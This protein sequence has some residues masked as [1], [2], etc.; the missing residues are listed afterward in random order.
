MSWSASLVRLL[1]TRAPWAVALCY[2]LLIQAALAP[3][4]GTA[5]ALS[6]LDPSA[7]V[8]CL[9]DPSGDAHAPDDGAHHD[10]GCCLPAARGTLAPPALVPGEP[11]AI[12]EAPRR[13]AS[14]VHPA[15]PA[16]APPSIDLPTR[17]VRAPP[18]LLA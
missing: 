3:V 13:L 2:A 11:V 17:P 18:L 9:A 1:R 6:A 15:A 12:P 14:H 5:R 16:R 7:A 8:L 4:V 10:M